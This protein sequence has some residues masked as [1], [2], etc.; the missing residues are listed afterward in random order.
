MPCLPLWYWTLVIEVTSVSNW[1]ERASY[2]IQV[3]AKLSKGQG[4]PSSAK[5]N[6]WLMACCFPCSLFFV[7]CSFEFSV[8]IKRS[9]LFFFSRLWR[10]ETCRDGSSIRS[11]DYHFWVLMG[12]SSSVAE[13]DQIK[14]TRR[15]RHVAD[16]RHEHLQWFVAPCTSSLRFLYVRLAQF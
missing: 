3:L 2:H 13:G 8:W 7:A 12:W 15:G 9:F 4:H 11:Q 6:P 10:D 14:E 5:K 16:C 1:S